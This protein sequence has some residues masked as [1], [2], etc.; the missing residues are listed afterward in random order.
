VARQIPNV[1]RL[2]RLHHM[3]GASG[4]SIA[5]LDVPNVSRLDR[6]HHL[7]APRRAHHVP[8]VSRLDRLHHGDTRCG[9]RSLSSVPNVSR[10]DRLHHTC[11]SCS[12]WPTWRSPKRQPPGQAS[13]RLAPDLVTLQSQTSAAWTGFITL[14]FEGAHTTVSIVPNVSRLDRLHHAEQVAV[15]LWRAIRP[16]RQ[17]FGQA[18]SRAAREPR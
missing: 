11:S 12:R 4:N 18:S 17:P 14:A 15:D 5:A 9:Y 7:P 3:K 6:L 1:S 13:S 10:L 8:N 2:D 16:K